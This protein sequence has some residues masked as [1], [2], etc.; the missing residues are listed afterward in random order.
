M[1][2]VAK[3][4]GVSTAT[5]A[6]VIYGNGYVKL[7]TKEVVQKAIAETGY[8]PNVLARSLR[9]QRTRLIGLVVTDSQVSTF[10]QSIARQIHHE[11]TLHGYTL[12]TFNNSKDPAAEIGGVQRLIDFNVDGLIFCAA[13]SVAAIQMAEKSGIQIIQ[14]ERA[15]RDFG[16]AILIDPKPGM[17]A[18][19]ARLCDLNH[20]R[21]AFIGGEP[22]AREARLGRFES[23]E[24]TRIDSFISALSARDITVPPALVRLGPYWSGAGLKTP[25]KEH[26]GALMAL[27][28]RPTAIVCGSDYL[29]ATVMQQAMARG[30][31]IPDDLSVVGFDDSF[32]FLLAPALSS[33]AQPVHAIAEVSV[34]MLLAMLDSDDVPTRIKTLPTY[35]V[36][37]ASTGSAPLHRG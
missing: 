30:M 14:I 4:A 32:A 17:N 20:R 5:V 31:A 7:S 1:M 13:A 19:I 3:R 15:Y 9:Y 35:F 16:G 12:L 27:P 29:A 28:N 22:R 36:E 26:F 10:H 23:V 37:R 21:I 25:G 8:R 2:L 6:R 18:A 34:S 24:Q 11:A 33:I